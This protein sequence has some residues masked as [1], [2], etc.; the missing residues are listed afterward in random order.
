MALQYRRQLPDLTTSLS[1]WVD[2]HPILVATLFFAS[3]AV[4][5]LLLGIAEMKGY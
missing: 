5:S 2:D 3:A 4:M 1:N